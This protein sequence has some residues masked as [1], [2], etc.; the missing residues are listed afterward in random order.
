M[1]P[2]VIVLCDFRPNKVL[3]VNIVD[4]II[5]VETII[6][7][8]AKCPNNVN[9]YIHINV[10]IMTIITYINVHLKRIEV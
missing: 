4:A 7:Y 8:I 5:T 3:K 2:Q 6:T 9:N 1:H 10:Q